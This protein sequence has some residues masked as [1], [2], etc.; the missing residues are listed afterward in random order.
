MKWKINYDKL[1]IVTSVACAIHCTIL[2]LCMSSL[3]LLG[4]EILENK[5]VEYGM[6]LLAFVFGVASLWHGFRHHHRKWTPV[7]LFS[8]GFS[9]LVMNQLFT[10]QFVF[11]LIPVA[12]VCIVL[13][14][15]MNIFYVKRH[16]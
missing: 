5:A 12:A 6:I 7:L 15:G 1:G 11:I 14:H 2:P 13:A 3:P 9:C 8:A 4:I 16:C 10:E